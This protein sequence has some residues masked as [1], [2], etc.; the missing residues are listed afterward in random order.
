MGDNLATALAYR[1]VHRRVSVPTWVVLYINII[2][3]MAVANSVYIEHTLA[4]DH[5]APFGGRLWSI[6]LLAASLVTLHGLLIDYH[7]TVTWGA[8]LGYMSW[9]M[10]LLSWIFIAGLSGAWGVP[11]LAI[12]MIIFFVFVHLKHSI[13]RRWEDA[14]K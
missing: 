6:M 13:I 14:Q 12:P 8:I 5:L 9:V 3:S 4:F 7:R 11:A 10:A 2:I 1:I